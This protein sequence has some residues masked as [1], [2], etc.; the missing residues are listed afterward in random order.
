MF[1]ILKKLVPES[2]EHTLRTNKEDVPNYES[3]LK[4]VQQML[5]RL[6][7]KSHPI[8]MDVDA[9][10]QKHEDND[11]DDH[12]HKTNNNDEHEQQ[13]TYDDE[14]WPHDATIDEYGNYVEAVGKGKNSKGKGKMARAMFHKILFHTPTEFVI[15]VVK[16]AT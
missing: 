9:L 5:Q 7:E 6:Y 15:I 8:P 16:R 14:F 4:N 2:I 1:T 11:H 10:K 3:A 12:D 13:P